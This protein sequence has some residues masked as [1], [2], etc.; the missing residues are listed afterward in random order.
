M[1]ALGALMVTGTKR[2]YQAGFVAM[3]TEPVVSIVNVT[4]AS[5]EE[6]RRV[7]GIGRSLAAKIVARQNQLTTVDDLLSVPGVGRITLAKLRG[8]L[9]D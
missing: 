4:T 8:Y 3:E 6:L 2:R 9:T 7:P 1:L 5:A